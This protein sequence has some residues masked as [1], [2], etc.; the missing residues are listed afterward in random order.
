MEKAKVSLSLLTENCKKGTSQ[1]E[2]P[3]LDHEFQSTL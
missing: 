3:W 1:G 2:M